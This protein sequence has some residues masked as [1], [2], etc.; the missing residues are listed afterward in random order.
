LIRLCLKALRE[1]GLDKDSTRY[2][3]DGREVTAKEQMEIELKR[4]CDKKFESYFLITRDL[5][6]C[7]LDHGWPLGPSRGSAGGSLVCY[8]L[9]IISINPLRFKG[10]SFNRFLSPARGG[11][12]LKVT[13]E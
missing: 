1:R 12:M 10:M 6:R 8:L 3:I 2:L 7:S 4:L 9:D 5:V 13:M 11:D